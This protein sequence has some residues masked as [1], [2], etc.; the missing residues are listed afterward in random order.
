MGA[1]SP[2]LSIDQGLGALLNLVCLEIKRGLEAEIAAKGLDLRY[3]QFQ[4]LKWLALV[5]PMMATELARLVEL[6]AGAITRQLD[7]L[8]GRDLLRR[9]PHASDRR[10]L[11]I[12]LTDLGQVMWQ[13]LTACNEHVS[14]A[15]HHALGDIESKRLHNDLTRVLKALRGKQ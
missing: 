2:T 9:C 4:I 15:A 8:E 14:D 10:A 13:E 12:E 3:N 5:G 7:Y 6:D 1:K 11:R